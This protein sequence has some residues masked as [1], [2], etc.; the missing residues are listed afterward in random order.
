MKAFLLIIAF[1]I[2]GS[3][4]SALG[5]WLKLPAECLTKDNWTQY[6]QAC[7]AARKEGR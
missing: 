5:L 2:A 7:Y 4:G 3:V 6:T 1:L